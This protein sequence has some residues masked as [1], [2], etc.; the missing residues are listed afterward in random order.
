MT[1]WMPGVKH[2]QMEHKDRCVDDRTAL[3]A[4]KPEAHVHG[5]MFA[6]LLPSDF[7]I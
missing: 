3:E 7:Q 5:S 6:G 4:Q 1:T 2:Q